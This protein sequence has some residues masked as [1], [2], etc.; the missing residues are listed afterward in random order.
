MMSAMLNVKARACLHFGLIYWL[1]EITPMSAA[2]NICVVENL[3]YLRASFRRAIRIGS[4]ENDN[5]FISSV[6]KGMNNQHSKIV[7][8]MPY[9]R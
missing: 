4:C 7:K 6:T 5:I 9:I 3:T 1:R 8:K 2:S